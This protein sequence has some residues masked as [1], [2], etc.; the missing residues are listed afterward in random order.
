[1]KESKLPENFDIQEWFSG[2]LKTIALW[3]ITCLVQAKW[4]DREFTCLRSCCHR[5]TANSPINSFL[6]I[7]FAH[8]LLYFGVTKL[9]NFVWRFF[10]QNFLC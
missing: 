4:W 7:K 6:G 8:Y 5:K 9:T 3:K 10:R 2:R 1:M